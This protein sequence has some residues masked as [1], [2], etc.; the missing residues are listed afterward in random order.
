MG[1]KGVMNHGSFDAGE[2]QFNNTKIKKSCTRGFN[3]VRSIIPTST[4]ER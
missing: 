3:V 4:D 2:Y 1:K